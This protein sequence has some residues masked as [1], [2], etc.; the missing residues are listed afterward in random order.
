MSIR[1]YAIV[2]NHSHGK[3]V[4]KKLRPTKSPLAALATDIGCIKN[5]PLNSVERFLGIQ[6]EK[7]SPF[8]AS[9]ETWWASRWEGVRVSLIHAGAPTPRAR[10]FSCHDRSNALRVVCHLTDTPLGKFLAL[11]STPLTPL[12]SDFTFATASSFSLSPFAFRLRRSA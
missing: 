11:R 12:M 6:S 4:S 8:S 1:Q 10:S 2:I 7:I 3:P 5:R 9:R